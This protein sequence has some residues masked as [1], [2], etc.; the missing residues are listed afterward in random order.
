[1]ATRP[2]AATIEAAISR[3][4]RAPSVHNCQP[5]QWSA[6]EHSIQLFSDR[7]RLV[8]G[9]DPDDRDLLMSCGAALHHL[10]VAL[11]A[12]GWTPRV[13]R[14]PDPHQPD[15]LASVSMLPAAP[16]DY[17][18]RMSVAIDRRRS[19]RRQLSSTAVPAQLLSRLTTAAQECG[20]LLA[21][22]DADTRAHL[23]SAAIDAARRYTPASYQGELIDWSARTPL[24]DEEAVQDPGTAGELLVLAS[25]SDDTRS[26]LL[27]GEALSR[28]LLHANVLGL[29]ACPLTQP[30]E[31]GDTRRFLRDELLGGT[32]TPQVLVRVGW[33]PTSLQLLPATPRRR[34]DEVLVRSVTEEADWA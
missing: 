4:C 23:V 16:T 32:W 9:G 15:H 13:H 11:E 12:A 31:G 26:Q 2:D 5:W 19:D 6:S 21:A 1:M 14:L 22:T 20:A 17:A 29:A 7:S 28:V 8:R 30:L 24:G 18:L 33:L 25:T 34:L 27:A 10:H 3:A